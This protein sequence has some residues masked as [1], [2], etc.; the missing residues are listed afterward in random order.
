MSIPVQL[1]EVGEYL[2]DIVKRVRALGMPGD[3]GDL[4]RGQIA[5]DI[6]GELLAFLRQLFDFSRNINSGLSLHVAQLFN[7]VFEIG[8]GL[9]EIEESFLGHKGLLSFY[10]LN[11]LGTELACF[12][13]QGSVAQYFDVQ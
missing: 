8:N 1:N 4:P 2:I 9:L 12:A 6:F 11:L 7:L 10:H 13:E 5:V 3:F